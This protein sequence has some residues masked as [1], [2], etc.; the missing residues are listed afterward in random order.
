MLPLRFGGLFVFVDCGYFWYFFDGMEGVVSDGL[1]TARSSGK[2]SGGALV[3][4]FLEG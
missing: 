4:H 3:F 2:A 1:G